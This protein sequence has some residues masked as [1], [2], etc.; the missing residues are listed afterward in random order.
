[1]PTEPKR[2][3]DF[4][5]PESA[6]AGRG[7]LDAAS[8]R[9]TWLWRMRGGADAEIIARFREE[10]ERAARG[11]YDDWASQPSGR[12]ALIVLL[13]QFSRSVF[14]GS[15]RAFAQD[16]RALALSLEGLEC[17]HYEALSEPW[18]KVAFTLPLGHCEGPDHLAR[19]DRLIALREAIAASCAPNLRSIYAS[20][21]A[22]ARDVR[23]VIA[24]F[25]RH[26][27]R[28]ALLGRASTEAEERYLLEGRFPHHGILNS[29]WS[30][31]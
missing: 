4:F 17:G 14:R 27:H 25:G 20:L 19:I 1:M 6:Q 16:P 23:K 15:P 5:F 3:L 22:Q 21:A 31:P 26:P 2:V 18:L 10:T 8:H 28:N 7:E 13:D 9:E 12:L 29:G 30:E 11:E 24:A